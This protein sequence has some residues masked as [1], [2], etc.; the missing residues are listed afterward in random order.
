MFGCTDFS[1]KAIPDIIPPPRER[2]DDRVNG[3]QI[4]QQFLADRSLP[5]DDQRIVKRVD[6]RQSA[7][8]LEAAR[9]SHCLIVASAVNHGLG[10]KSAQGPYFVPENPLRQADHGAKT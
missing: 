6:H 8:G 3:G 10:T 5:R 2:G 4:L 7:L 1:V 9:V